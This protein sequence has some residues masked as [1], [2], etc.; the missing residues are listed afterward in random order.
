MITSLRLVDFKNFADET[1]RVGPFTVIVG[2]NASGKSNIRDAFRFLHGIGRGY[3]LAEILGGR[4]GQGRQ[5]EWERIRGGNQI[6]RFDRA[7]FR[8]ISGSAGLTAVPRRTS[9]R[10]SF[11]LDLGLRLEEDDVVYTVE[12]G[13]SARRSSQ[14]LVI[15]EGLRIGS[16]EVFTSR[17]DESAGAPEPLASDETHD[18]NYITLVEPDPL[19]LRLGPSEQGNSTEEVPVDARQPALAQIPKRQ[20]V[21]ANH[22]D[23]VEQVI[24]YL[25]AMRF[26]ALDPYMMRQPV[27]PDQNMLGDS[28][29]NL[30]AVLH[31]ICSDRKRKK[32]LI[33]W[34]RGLTPTDVQDLEFPVDPITGRIH[35]VIREK[36]ERRFVAESA[37]DG[38]LRLLGVLAALFGSKPAKL[39]FFE[40]IEDGFHPSR[41]RLLL[42]LI[43]RETVRRGIQ[44]VTTTHS[45]DL[46]AQANDRT[47][48]DMSLVCRREDSENTVIRPVTK[49]PNAGRLRRSQGLGRLHATGWMEDMIAF[50]GDDEAA[51]K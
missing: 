33:S 4:F 48:G 23:R 21:A 47:F 28:G 29:V 7:A 22:R 18:G 51:P 12:V 10:S 32:T 20:A 36:N 2:T 41:L 13:A 40:D 26:P 50:E 8:I 27:L 6:V 46:L 43:E 3:T 38:T 30:P 5:E 9:A 39:Y 37:S 24:D 49:L 19:L 31:G 17:R 35:L 1:L 14:F 42:E 25:A 15:G 44:V 34:T 11:R 16:R 45:P